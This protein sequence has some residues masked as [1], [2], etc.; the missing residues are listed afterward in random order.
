MHDVTGTPGGLF[1][2]NPSN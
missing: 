2:R 1:E